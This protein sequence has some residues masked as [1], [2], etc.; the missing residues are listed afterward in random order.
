MKPPPFT[1][2]VPYP[3]PHVSLPTANTPPIGAHYTP[4]DPECGSGNFLAKIIG[5]PPYKGGQGRSDS[6]I[7]TNGWLML[8]ICAAAALIGMAMLA[9][10]AMGWQ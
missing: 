7:S 9:A 6:E 4:I 5:N 8:A 2:S 3:R 10:V 1:S